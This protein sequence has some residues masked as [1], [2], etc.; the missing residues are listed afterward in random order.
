MD[1]GVLRDD[2]VEG[3]VH[4]AK[5]V[6]ESPVLAD[7]MRSVPRHAFVE[8]ESD[9]VAYEDR[10]F[11]HRGTTV[12]APSMVA[13]LLELLDPGDGHDTLVVG[14]GV[15]Y[16]AAVLAEVVGPRHVTGIDLSR[17]LVLDARRNLAEAGYEAV[18]ID[19]RDGAEG[20]PEYAPF[21]R[22]LVEAAA[23]DPPPALLD[24]LAPGGRLVMPKGSSGQELVAV[25]G[26]D[27]V[28]AS[29]GVRFKPLLLEGE[30]AGGIERNRTA[31]ETR[32]RA[33]EAA[34]SRSGWERD[35]IDWEG[36]GD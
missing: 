31:R 33:A 29:G 1:L 16:T 35:W 19:R 27:V 5:G 2:M 12:L 17:P 10:A 15:G 6:L 30:Q 21:D 26:G 36:A 3:L 7:A 8:A 11:A 4:D 25:E 14:A 18:L 34:T 23:V 20:F 32:E 9:E 28:E 13:R 22:I 24:Q